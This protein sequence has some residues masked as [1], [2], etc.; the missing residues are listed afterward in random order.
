MSKPPVLRRD[1]RIKPQDTGCLCYVVRTGFAT[2]EVSFPFRDALTS[3]L[4]SF[5]TSSVAKLAFVSSPP[6]RP[7]VSACLLLSTVTVLPFPS[8]TRSR[9][10]PECR[11]YSPPPNLIHFDWITPNNFFPFPPSLFK[12]TLVRTFMS[13]R[14]HVCLAAS[15]R[16]FPCFP[17]TFVSTPETPWGLLHRLLSSFLR[18]PHF[19]ECCQQVTV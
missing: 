10:S 12:G 4:S 7:L 16:L 15:T 1:R 19:F 17:V 2:Q 3:F 5:R 11:C 13:S 6:P 8:S 9:T 14:E 18:H